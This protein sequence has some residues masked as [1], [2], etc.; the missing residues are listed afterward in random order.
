MAKTLIDKIKTSFI[1]WLMHDANPSSY[2]MCDFERIKY[3]LRPCDVLLIEGRSRV[4]EVIKTI[5]QSVWS[6]AA[7]YIGRIHE[8]E[9]PIL[10]ERVQ[11]FYNGSPQD[12]L[13]I[14]S[15]LGRG[16]IISPLTNYQDDHIRI[17]RPKGIA[18]QDAQH[19]IGFAIGRLGRRY[20][21]RHI[22]D[23]ARFLFP[24][25]FLPRRWRSSLF[26]HN[27]G[28]PTHEICS[29]MIAE[30]FGSVQFPILP[31]VKIHSKNGIQLYR[32]NPLL[33]TPSDFD[34]SPYFE[35]IKYPIFELSDRALYRE[36]PWNKKGILS[37]DEIKYKKRHAVIS[38]EEP[39]T[40]IKEILPPKDEQ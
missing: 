25:S 8:I 11:E 20:A 6:H 16:T 7:L 38:L 22:L 39:E 30:A 34:Y 12:Q 26:R 24:W 5:T 14:E 33:C 40:P 23:L 28:T 18:R 37:H 15:L 2:P 31:L 13:I 32:R 9:N 21:V 29:S 3:E 10:R 1:N 4:S 35:I 19:V 17:C 27:A 36:L